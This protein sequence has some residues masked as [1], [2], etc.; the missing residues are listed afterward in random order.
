MKTAAKGIC[1]AMLLLLF[2]GIGVCVGNVQERGVR[3]VGK[4][5]GY[6]D[7]VAVVVRDSAMGNTRFATWIVELLSSAGWT[8]KLA[9]LVDLADRGWWEKTLP[10]LVV[11]PNGRRVPADSAPYLVDH[12]KRSGRLLVFG[13]PLFEEAL[14]RVPGPTPAWKTASE[15]ERER[16]SVY[17]QGYLFPNLTESE[18]RQWRYDA[19]HPDALGKWRREVV[20]GPGAK[21]MPQP[22]RIAFRADLELKG[23]GVFSRRFVQSPFPP[24]H[25]LT[26]FWAK[27]TRDVRR[28]MVEWR[29][30][31]GSRWYA[32]VPV[33]DDWRRV[34]LTPEEFQFRPDSPTR[35]KRGQPGDSLRLEKVRALVF[36]LEWVTEPGLHT[37]WVAG[38]GTAADP[39]AGILKPFT[40]PVI[41]G[42]SPSYKFYPVDDIWGK[43]D[44]G[45]GYFGWPTRA[46]VFL[47]SWK[48]GEGPVRAVCIISRYVDHWFRERNRRLVPLARSQDDIW[49]WAV[50]SDDSQFRSTWW[51]G[52]G[53]TDENFWM[54]N[55]NAFAQSMGH[56][57]DQLRGG[58]FLLSGGAEDFTYAVKDP[59]R[60]GAVVVNTSGKERDVHL[61]FTAEALP[62]QMG[63]PPSFHYSIGKNVTVKGHSRVT[64][65]PIEM[66][67]P[68]GNYLLSVSVVP[69]SPK[70]DFR[71]DAI[72][73]DV[74][75][76]SLPKAQP[77]DR[78]RVQDGHFVYKGRRWFA[79]G[80]NFWPRYVA[81]QEPS[82]YW[83]H[84]LD[85][86]NYEPGLVV[87]DLNILR[88]IGFNC[89]SIQYS[90]PRQA[91]AL[92][93]FL[94]LC[95]EFGIKVN[96]FIAGAHPLHFQPDLVKE[97]IE[98][99]RL[100]EQPA[101]FAYDIA[102]EPTWGN[103]QERR[104]HDREWLHWVVENYGS[105]DRAEADW[106]YQLPRGEDG[107]ATVPKDEQ[108]TQDGPWRVMTAAYRRF[109]DDFISRRYRAVCQWIRNL[110]PNHLIGARTGY[111]GGPFGA[112]GALPFDLTAGA[113]H[114]DFVSPE[115]WNLAWLGARST[116]D[117]ERASFIPAY[118]RWAGKGKPVFWAEF[119][120]TIR[121]GPF[122][123]EWHRD[124]QR[125]KAQADLYSAMY[126]LILKTDCDGA[127][128]WWFPGGYRIDERSDFG[129]VDPSGRLRPAAL[130]AKNVSHSILALPLTRPPDWEEIVIDRDENARGAIALLEK[131][132]DRCRELLKKGRSVKVR[133]QATGLTSDHHIDVA[134]GNTPWEP[135]KP[136]KFLN[137]EIC[138]VRLSFDE[139]NWQEL[140]PGE[141][142]LE[143]NRDRPATFYLRIDLANT[144]EVTWLP[145]KECQDPDRGIRILIEVGSERIEIPLPKGL[146]PFG[147][148]TLTTTPLPIP[149]SK[150]GPWLLR[151]TLNWRRSP[152]GE[153]FTSRCRID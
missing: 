152:F 128:G 42:L 37:F 129:I 141:N 137:G 22:A 151:V 38:F 87:R 103:Y 115:G 57:L 126:D 93:D 145:P 50:I 21:E 29:E 99:A 92:R 118:A 104:R 12:L 125:L 153:I 15:I 107:Q 61:L 122:S 80:I 88:E 134:V 41:E 96:L 25:S 120:L 69:A 123:L 150:G 132:G 56:I 7:G 110:D 91:V 23:W 33:S 83:V 109:L 19:S 54:L 47:P 149:P 75:V 8:V 73:T 67:L 85:P 142:A 52:I 3:G 81:G 108:L 139:K 35:G 4:A 32:H 48:K 106:G 14:V 147:D 84:W 11:L 146:E 26:I 59:V 66:A 20:G 60:S 53:L 95:Q 117:F 131:W 6:R 46:A 78:I 135:G 144:G 63:T 55:R 43:D 148:L 124:D 82:E 101:L 143:T 102:W 44:Y 74:G 89:V 36:G 98:A 77:E 34:V 136:P 17:P 140:K 13:L 86:S 71:S 28:L 18:V 138:R 133:T 40:P 119:G 24:G 58:V 49:M 111:G 112:E 70:D 121:V 1:F 10:E 113:K 79:F 76:R 9:N 94:R 114:L 90:N 16:H 105:L 51:L 97:L 68:E 116:A 65:D 30:E 64:V 31:D 62:L 39:Y 100:S 5:M 27:G 127:M 45:L 2:S 72:C 130:V